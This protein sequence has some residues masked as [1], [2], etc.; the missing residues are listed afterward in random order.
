MEVVLLKDILNFILD[1]KEEVRS[2]LLNT[3]K[4]EDIDYIVEY[5]RNGGKVSTVAS[6][7]TCEYCKEIAGAIN[8]YTDGKWIWPEWLEHYLLIHEL[9]LPN[10]FI[11]HI[12]TNNYSYDE[13]LV[14]RIVNN[15]IEI[16]V[17]PAGGS[18]NN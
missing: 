4:Y 9:E 11:L 15:E 2:E 13:N 10:E 5:I 18:D 1:N 8:Y 17:A 7:K 3:S 6:K 16:D 12:R 14:E